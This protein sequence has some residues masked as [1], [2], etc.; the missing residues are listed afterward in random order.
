MFVGVTER[1]LAVV[2]RS[3][4]RVLL[5]L[6]TQLWLLKQGMQVDADSCKTVVV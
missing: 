2:S 1:R 6:R 3:H 4:E 5:A